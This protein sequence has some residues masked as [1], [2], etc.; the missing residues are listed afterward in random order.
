M[1]NQ[2]WL[3]ATETQMVEYW[4]SVI[5]K[6]KWYQIPRR[7]TATRRVRYWKNKVNNK[8]YGEGEG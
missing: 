7:I 6:L 3:P 4:Q 1:S 5:Y 8:L 2:K